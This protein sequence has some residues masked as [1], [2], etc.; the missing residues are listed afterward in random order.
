MAGPRNRKTK[1]RIKPNEE[2]V[3]TI[4][5][6]KSPNN[7]KELKFFLGA[8]QHLEKFFLK[9]LEMTGRLRKILKMNEHW[10]WGDD[11][12]KDFN[13]IKRMLTAKFCLVHYA[14]DRENMDD[15]NRR[16]QNTLGTTFCQ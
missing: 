1:H 9:V 4:A 6:L 15:Y 3:K 13:R 2:K 16:N 7:S 10:E 11:Q 8:I 14:E 12:K 5:K